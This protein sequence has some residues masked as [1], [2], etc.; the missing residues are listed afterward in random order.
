MCGLLAAGRR[1]AWIGEAALVEVAGLAR[2]QDG[3]VLQRRRSGELLGWVR[4]ER[5]S[6]PGHCRGGSAPA[7]TEFDYR[8]ARIWPRQMTHARPARYCELIALN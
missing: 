5:K 8:P 7:G 4:A 1:P 3:I 2:A 6:H